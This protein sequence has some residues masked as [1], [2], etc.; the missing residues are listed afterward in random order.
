MYWDD[1]IIISYQEI[2]RK[3]KKGGSNSKYGHNVNHFML[4]STNQM[5]GVFFDIWW[6]WSSFFMEE[7]PICVIRVYNTISPTSQNAK[8]STSR[9]TNPRTALSSRSHRAP[10][11]HAPSLLVR[12]KLSLPDWDSDYNGWCCTKS[13]CFIKLTSL[14]SRAETLTCRCYHITYPVATITLESKGRELLRTSSLQSCSFTHNR[15]AVLVL[16][17]VSVRRFR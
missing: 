2:P 17:P 11:P 1:F 3:R 8:H 15:S 7:V 14:H 12:G 10:L 4:K 6:W 5:Q 16:Y 13:W 9:T